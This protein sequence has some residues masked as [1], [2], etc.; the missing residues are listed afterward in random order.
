M[1]L[2]DILFTMILL[3]FSIDTITVYYN[4]INGFFSSKHPNLGNE[5]FSKTIGK[6][7]SSD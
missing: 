2:L 5:M 3:Y 4:N 7:S 6:R 1:Y